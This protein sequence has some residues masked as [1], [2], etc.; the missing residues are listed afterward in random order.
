MDRAALEQLSKDALIV[1]LLAQEAR[2]SELERCLG[3]NSSNSG[4]PPSSDGLKQPPRT[5]SLRQP[6]GK[7]PGGQRGHPGETLRRSETP[8]AVID[9]Y[10]P[11][12]AAC[13]EP[14]TEAMA[15]DFAARQVFDL[16]EPQPLIVAF[17]T[18]HGGAEMIF[19][20]GKRPNLR[21]MCRTL[22]SYSLVTRRAASG[23]CAAHPHTSCD[24]GFAP[25]LVWQPRD[26]ER[27]G[28]CESVPPHRARSAE[29]TRAARLFPV[30]Q[31]GRDVTGL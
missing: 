2:I 15:T 28:G 18:L 3:L 16:P 13:G 4:K 30:D 21:G 20:W 9:H 27:R 17:R 26:S 31:G 11:N 14:L 19:A 29:A 24:I 1:L 5:S 22:L 10:P 25:W 12:C 23:G 6:S 7:K 8:D